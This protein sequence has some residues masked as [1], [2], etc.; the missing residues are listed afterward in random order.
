VSVQALVYRAADLGI[1]GERLKKALFIQ[2]G[3]AGWRKKEPQA[4]AQEQ[5]TR[6]KRL[7][8]RALSEDVIS[9]SKAAE[10]LDE[11]TRGLLESLNQPSQASDGPPPGV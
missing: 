4:V 5:P 8:L 11:S 10:L 7:C 6:F 9:P 3:K 1:I 2:F